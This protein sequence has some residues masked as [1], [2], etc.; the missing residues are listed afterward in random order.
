MRLPLFVILAAF[1]LAAA[2]RSVGW[3]MQPRAKS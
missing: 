1:I 2:Q 3:M